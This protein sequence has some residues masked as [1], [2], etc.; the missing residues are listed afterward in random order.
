MPL[1][2]KQN[3]Y[4]SQLVKKETLNYIERLISEFN[5]VFVTPEVYKQ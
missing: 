4:K 5:I 3:H 1:K 2:T